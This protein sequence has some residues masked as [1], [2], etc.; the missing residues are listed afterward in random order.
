MGETQ[1]RAARFG[2]GFPEHFDASNRLTPFREKQTEL[3]EANTFG[4]KIREAL[5]LEKEQWPE[6]PPVQN[7]EEFF[8]AAKEIVTKQWAKKVTP[9]L[10]EQCSAWAEQ[11]EG[12]DLDV[13]ETQEM[14][15]DPKG[16]E[17]KL[18]MQQFQLLEGELRKQLP[19]AW[20]SL[21]LAS[22][23]RQL[24]SVALSREWLKNMPETEVSKLGMT[25]AELEIFL[26][27]AGI[28]GKYIDS[29]Y[30][31][32]VEL[33][34]LASGSLP[35]A[36]GG[37]KGADRLYDLQRDRSRDELDIKTYPEV[38]P[39]E[40][41]HMVP[42]FRAL[43]QKVRE[44]TIRGDLPAHYTQFA[45]HLDLLSKTYG[46]TEKDP[47]TLRA[48]WKQLMADAKILEKTPLPI[49]IIPQACPAVAGDAEKVDVE[50]RLGIRTPETKSY[51]SAAQYITLKG[52]QIL[53]AA[54][55]KFAA[56]RTV[57]PLTLNIQPFAF[58]P[59]MYWYTRGESDDKRIFSHTDA[60]RDVA[61]KSEMPCLQKLFKKEFDP[62]SYMDASI[63]A[64][65]LHETG[66]FIPP[67]GDDNVKKRIEKQLPFFEEFKA[68]TVGT[69]IFRESDPKEA[70]L[71]N[72]DRETVFY[73]LLGVHLD[74][75]KNKSP[76]EGKSGERYYMCAVAF[77]LE[78]LDKNILKKE[79]A[80]YI[81]EDT[82]AG[83]QAIANIGDRI[84][85]NYTKDDS[86][87]EECTNYVAQIRSAKNDPRL[88]EILNILKAA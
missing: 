48:E 87:V 12:G 50:I 64:T 60:V 44:R 52:Q 38:F 74:Y 8:N 58:G 55:D 7:V 41:S 71:K 17:E 42:A 49:M 36:L 69:K 62:T 5:K 68:W 84:F 37:Q 30:I 33:A 15:S 59:N 73:A 31:R 45:E 26:D 86:T 40:W 81:I 10:N 34:D 53:D 22:S 35:T 20:R 23:E 77:L 11:L 66:H 78:L 4:I 27:I 65:V 75:L 63:M 88:R 28:F 54:Q 47:S 6:C 79:G 13:Q 39:F 9:F 80:A 43:A 57:P 67:K 19:E 21:L 83:L 76:R 29:A 25:K 2:E 51:E 24:A 82:E 1:A 61:R 14:L 70:T 18:Q 3:P 16:L 72:Y 56:Q 32:Q 46:S 85:H